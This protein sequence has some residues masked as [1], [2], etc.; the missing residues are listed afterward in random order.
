MREPAVRE[1]WNRL[2]NSVDVGLEPERIVVI[3]LQVPLQPHPVS[4]S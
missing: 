1:A 4:V 3:S 2:A